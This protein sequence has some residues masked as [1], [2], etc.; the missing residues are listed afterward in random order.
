L[1]DFLDVSLPDFGVCDSF[2]VFGSAGS[3]FLLFLFAGGLRTDLAGN[4]NF[5]GLP[6]HLGQK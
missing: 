1:V 3:F 2:P 5:D 6:E 4:L